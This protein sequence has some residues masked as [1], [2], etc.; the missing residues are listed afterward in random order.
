WR[1]RSRSLRRRLR[2]PSTRAA[3]T[4]SPRASPPRRPESLAELLG[5]QGER[6]EPPGEVNVAGEVQRRL[7][8]RAT[9]ADAQ[10]ELVDAVPALPAALGGVEIGGERPDGGVV[11]VELAVRVA[12]GRDEEERTPASAVQV[13]LVD[14]DRL[15]RD[16]GKYGQRVTELARVD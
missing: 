16:V 13:R 7:P 5:E 9:V 6:E 15:A 2:R 4:G 10:H 8:R 14:L 3:R 12:A 11:D 1:R